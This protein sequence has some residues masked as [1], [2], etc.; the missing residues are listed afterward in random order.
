MIAVLNHHSTLSLEWHLGKSLS[1]WTILASACLAQF[2]MVCKDADDGKGQ[3]SR[4]CHSGLIQLMLESTTT[5]QRPLLHQADNL[6]Q[7]CTRLTLCELSFSSLDWIRFLANVGRPGVLHPP[8]ASYRLQIR[9]S[10]R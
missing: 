1:D 6:R 10:Q 3:L 9:T 2:P 7:S 5:P 8:Y 4:K